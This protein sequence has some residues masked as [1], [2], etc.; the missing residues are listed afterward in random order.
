MAFT[1]LVWT[2]RVAWR[3]CGG[4]GCP[5]VV[6]RETSNLWLRFKRSLTC[7]ATSKSCFPWTSS[8]TCWNASRVCASATTA[9][10]VHRLRRTSRHAKSRTMFWMRPAAAGLRRRVAGEDKISS[11]L[12][13]RWSRSTSIFES[14]WYLRTNSI[15]PATE[16]LNLAS[17]SA[18]MILLLPLTATSVSGLA[19]AGSSKSDKLESREAMVAGRYES[20]RPARKCWRPSK[21]RMARGIRRCL[22]RP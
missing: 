1:G 8:T 16:R 4:S 17:S 7:L 19:I 2:S 14:A 12:A 6:V 10:R 18:R 5:N 20:L 21:V 15:P 13:R 9:V 3:C 11:S 22:L